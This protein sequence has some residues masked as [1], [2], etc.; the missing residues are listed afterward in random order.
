M[1]FPI[2]QANKEYFNQLSLRKNS[3]TIH[4]EQCHRRKKKCMKVCFYEAH[5]H[6]NH[7]IQ[8]YHNMP[9]VLMR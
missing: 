7:F 1:L 8:I 3:L 5:K 9:P 2:F 6:E 4:F